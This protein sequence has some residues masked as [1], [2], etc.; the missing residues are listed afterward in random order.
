MSIR[1]KIL[2]FWMKKFSRIGSK[3][4]SWEG[5]TEARESKTEDEKRQALLKISQSRYEESDVYR[6]DDVFDVDLISELEGKDI[7]EIGSNHG[8]GSF[9]YFEKYKAKSITGIDTSDRQAEISKLFF[10]QKGVTSNFY[11]QK[12]FAEDLPFADHSFDAIIS[13]DVFE[14]VQDVVQSLKECYRVLKPGGKAF[15]AFP[16]YYHL[17]E[18]HL[19]LVTAAPCIHWFYSPETLMEA[20]YDILDENPEY[21]DIK[22]QCR[23]PLKSWEKLYII[24]GTSLRQFKK[25][26]LLQ[27]WKSRKY[28]PLPLGANGKMIHRYP[29]LKVMKYLFSLGT[30]LPVLSEF[31]NNRIV[32]VLEK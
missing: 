30:K 20:Y 26:I 5:Y 3:R 29:M 27:P 14:H 15:I 4:G 19:T 16:S 7:L 12:A 8:G 6:M 18:H 24:N 22:G 17:T 11:F 2:I 28:I 25:Y 10:E 32:Y 23:K 13:Y 1:K 31:C 21:R 9:Y